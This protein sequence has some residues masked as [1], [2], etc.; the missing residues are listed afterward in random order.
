M[1]RDEKSLAAVF[2]NGAIRE[3]IA[4]QVDLSREQLIVFAWDGCSGERMLAREGKNV[5][6]SG[7]SVIFSE[8]PRVAGGFVDI[9]YIHLSPPVPNSATSSSIHEVID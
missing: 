1:I 3:R 5:G 8:L 6:S 4:K 7:S 2:E 9:H